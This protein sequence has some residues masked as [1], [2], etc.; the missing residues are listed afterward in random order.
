[1]NQKYLKLSK[2]NRDIYFMINYI[3]KYYCYS[4]HGVELYDYNVIINDIYVY[5]N[6]PFDEEYGGL[7]I[8]IDE[9]KNMRIYNNIKKEYVDIENNEDLNHI[10]YFYYG[11][12]YCTSLHNAV[13]EILLKV[14]I[15]E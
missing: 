12:I 1:M 4:A 7:F 5:D 9:N 14:V 6:K 3:K 15:N 10:S 13:K 8:C 11:N 2:S